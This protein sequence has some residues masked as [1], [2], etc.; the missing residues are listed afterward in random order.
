MDV[1]DAA[2]KEAEIKRT[3]FWVP[4]AAAATSAAG[5][6]AGTGTAPP[7]VGP[8]EPYSGAVLRLKDLVTLHL[9]SARGAA[10][11]G[12]GSGSSAAAGGSAASA[13]D[14]SGGD[15]SGDGAGASMG[16]TA[17]FMCP[18]CVKP[19]VYQQTYAMRPCGHVVCSD[20]LKRFVAPAARCFVCEAGVRKDDVIKL[21]VAGSSFAGGGG[22]Q[23][24]ARKYTPTLLS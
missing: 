19:I 24:E 23:V 2:T 8:R 15:E 16:S 14:G 9:S 10:A 4:E 17:R 6:G 13:G 3:S 7:D 1:R 12:S 22:T 20:C 21:Q 18:A 11:D 5:A